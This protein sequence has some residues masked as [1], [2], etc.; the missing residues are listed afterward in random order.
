VRLYLVVTSIALS[1]STVLAADPPPLWM[2]DGTIVACDQ[3]PTRSGQ[4]NC[5]KGH[6]VGWPPP[7]AYLDQ[8]SEPS[9]FVNKGSDLEE[10]WVHVHYFYYSKDL[11]KQCAFLESSKMGV[12]GRS[13]GDDPNDL[14]GLTVPEALRA[15]KNP[16]TILNQLSEFKFND[17]SASDCIRTGTAWINK[18][19]LRPWVNPMPP[20][21]SKP[22]KEGCVHEPQLKTL[23]QIS[24]TILGQDADSVDKIASSLGDCVMTPTQWDHMVEAKEKQHLHPNDSGYDMFFSNYWAKK[25]VSPIKLPTGR[26]LSKDDLKTIDG[27]ARTLMGEAQSCQFNLD[28]NEFNPGHFETLARVMVDRATKLAVREPQS[29]YDYD[30]LDQ[31]QMPAMEKIIS[32]PGQF[33]AWDVCK[34]AGGGKVGGQRVPLHC[35][36]YNKSLKYVLCPQNKKNEEKI[37]GPKQQLGEYHNDLW[38]WA[39]EVATEAYLGGPPQNTYQ[40]THPWSVAGRPEPSTTIE[41]Y[42]HGVSMH[43]TVRAKYTEMTNTKLSGYD[44]KFG[45]GRCPRLRLWGVTMKPSRASSKNRRK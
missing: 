27:I 5:E 35:D 1:V 8:L 40:E 12:P 39:V 44:L 45:N 15:R 26:V 24:K 28:K 32:R 7:S 2:P 36:G 29:I 18:E 25:D 34:K 37:V 17:G 42:T 11:S 43:E 6:A 16:Q 22:E 9:T 33:D 31:S 3:P 13:P 20:K 19:R 23:R 41:A 4:I 21:L 38:K 10:E 30:R 14:D